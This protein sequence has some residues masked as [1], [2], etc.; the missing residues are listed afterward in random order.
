MH[1][2][3]ASQRMSSRDL[4]LSFSIQGL[5]DR[6]DHEIP[7]PS[8]DDPI[9]FL[10]APNG[11]GKS[12]L[13][14]LLADLAAENHLA[15]ANAF[16]QS[17]RVTYAS[18]ATLHAD[19]ETEDGECRTLTYRLEMPD[20][21]PV[22]QPIRHSALQQLAWEAA[23]LHRVQSGRLDRP[24][25]SDSDS[26]QFV[27]TP[28]SFS[29][30]ARGIRLRPAIKRALKAINATYLDVHRLG[31]G[32]HAAHSVREI[33][34]SLRQGVGWSAVAQVAKAATTVLRNARLAYLADSR[35]DEETFATRA[36]EALN[37][38]IE[39]DY[40]THG[41]VA[42]QL[43]QLKRLYERLGDLGVVAPIST[44]AI[45]VLGRLSD[46]N[47]AAVAVIRL[48]WQDVVR[49][50]KRLKS[51]VYGLELYRDAVNS[52]LQGKS[53][54]F[55]GDCDEGENEGQGLAVLSGDRAVPLDR[56]SD[57]E[58]HLLVI[59]GELLFGRLA[60]PRGLLLLD[61]PENSLHPE[62]QATLG[63]TLGRLAGKSRRRVLVATHSPIIIGDAWEKESS[64]DRREGK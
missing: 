9:R 61:E 44:Q 40:P 21:A 48:Y 18:G 10:T 53:V 3:A 63:A 43:G 12:T 28:G 39:V 7:L 46:S 54:R 19:R 27:F 33:E 42:Q 41:S 24:R 31:H 25:R 16:W 50:L 56:L 30:A 14:R 2:N 29:G 5:F 23:R 57:G 6:F 4:P 64:L 1:S 49:R 62:W 17:L 34:R 38:F 60:K 13:L 55:D 11:Y 59:F 52:L 36:V 51:R 47:G 22:T 37:N 58:Q 32:Q 45:D 26:H 20:K 35:A 15:V 8:L